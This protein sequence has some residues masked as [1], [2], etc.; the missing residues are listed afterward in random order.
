MTQKKSTCQELWNKTT[1]SQ[2][3]YDTVQN[4]WHVSEDAEKPNEERS[5][6]DMEEEDED[7]EYENLWKGR[8]NEPGPGTGPAT[9]EANEMQEVDGTHAAGH[10]GSPHPSTSNC[11]PVH[12]HS[13]YRHPPVHVADSS[14][15]SL[16]TGAV[17]PC[18]LGEA[19]GEAWADASADPEARGGGL[20]FAR[21]CPG[22]TGRG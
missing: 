19:L 21:P 6:D 17:R 4:A 22:I 9:Q 11:L 18:G 16:S 10:S 3:F 12:S 2:R 7:D 13:P 14:S 15:A 1:K 8:A 20:G 5:A